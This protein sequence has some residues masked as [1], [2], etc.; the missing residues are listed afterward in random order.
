MIKQGLGS[1]GKKYAKASFRCY[2]MIFYA[3]REK[4][5]ARSTRSN[6]GRL[7]KLQKDRICHDDDDI[8]SASQFWTIHS[9]IAESFAFSG[10]AP[11][12]A[13][14]EGI[15]TEMGMTGEWVKAEAYYIRRSWFTAQKRWNALFH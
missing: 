11:S 2:L 5:N 10:K 15:M 12:S 9:H 3:K 1:Y 13:Q 14:V 4:T 8:M 6:Q 7:T